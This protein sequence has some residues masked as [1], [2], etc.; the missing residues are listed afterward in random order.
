M[1]RISLFACMALLLSCSVLMGCSTE[2]DVLPPTNNSPTV[3]NPANDAI[4]GSWKVDSIKFSPA[5][6]GMG[7]VLND[8]NHHSDEA[9]YSFYVFS[10][11]QLTLK[12]SNGSDISTFTYEYPVSMPDNNDN[13]SVKYNNQYWFAGTID[14]DQAQLSN[15]N[16]W[17]N[18][19]GNI[20]YKIV[21]LHRI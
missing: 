12:S 7:Y 6:Q 1:K 11:T 19:Q 8:E 21:Y 20:D 10:D 17:M 5:G 2:D 9:L 4:E 15:Y 3:N 14:A 13:A 18:A 16:E